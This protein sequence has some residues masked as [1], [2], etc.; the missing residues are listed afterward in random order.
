VLPGRGA[1]D[2]GVDLLLMSASAGAL[3]KEYRPSRRRRPVYTVD[4]RSL[5]GRCFP[6]VL[7]NNV[8]HFGVR[9]VASFGWLLVTQQVLPQVV[10]GHLQSLARVLVRVLDDGVRLFTQDVLGRRTGGSIAP[11]PR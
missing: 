11:F 3:E 9:V 2:P 10:F 6:N 7:G 1:D 8:E 4:A 5:G